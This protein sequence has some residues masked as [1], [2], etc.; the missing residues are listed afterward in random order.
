MNREEMVKEWAEALN[1]SVEDIKPIAEKLSDDDLKKM[2]DAAKAS[3][4]EDKV[5]KRERFTSDFWMGTAEGVVYNVA[6]GGA[7]V[8]GI[9]GMCKIIEACGGCPEEGVGDGE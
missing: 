7:I 9:W 1:K 6:V 4:A 2:V 5:V 8:L 3:R